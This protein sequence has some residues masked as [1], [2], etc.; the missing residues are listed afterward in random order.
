MFLQHLDL[1]DVP[2]DYVRLK[3]LI[4]TTDGVKVCNDCRSE[5]AVNP[6]THQVPSHCQKPKCNGEIVGQDCCVTCYYMFPTDDSD[7][8]RFL[9]CIPDNGEDGHNHGPATAKSW[10]SSSTSSVS[11]SSASSS[12]SNRIGTSRQ[13]ALARN[14]VQTKIGSR[15]AVVGAKKM[16]SSVNDEVGTAHRASSKESTRKNASKSLAQ[17]RAGLASSSMKFSNLAE[18]QGDQDADPDVQADADDEDEDDEEADSE[19]TEMATGVTDQQWTSSPMRTEQTSRPSSS[20]A[21]SSSTSSLSSTHHTT[22]NHPEADHDLPQ[23]SHR[24]SRNT[25]SSRK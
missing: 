9:V 13:Q 24:V 25:R 19:E 14:M 1:V 17:S 15:A 16:A 4:R 7:A 6:K 20:L 5:A 21:S 22:T 8:R 11:S 12:A 3:F 2:N 23:S 10:L 18:Y